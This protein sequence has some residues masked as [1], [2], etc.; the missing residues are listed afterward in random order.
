MRSAFGL[1]LNE[2]IIT[3]KT[4]GSYFYGI[5]YQ[6]LAKYLLENAPQE[7]K[8]DWN[9]HRSKY[10]IDHII[11]CKVLQL[12]PKKNILP[13]VQLIFHRDNLRWTTAKENQDKNGTVPE[14][15]VLPEPTKQIAIQLKPILNRDIFTPTKD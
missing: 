6:E 1:R 12:V 8:D 13:A 4:K 15:D 2:Y 5:N 14:F 9:K 11:P 7:L 10:H 3:G